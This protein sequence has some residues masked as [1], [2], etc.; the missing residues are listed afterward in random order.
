MSSVSEPLAP[1]STSVDS[2]VADP[3]TSTAEASSDASPATD[4]TPAD[5]APTDKP[6]DPALVTAGIATLTADDAPAL[7]RPKRKR[8]WLR[9]VG[10]VAGVA[11]I[12]TMTA[13]TGYVSDHHHVHIGVYP[14]PAS[15][16]TSPAVLRTSPEAKSHAGNLARFL[17][18]VPSGGKQNFKPR[19]TH[20]VMSLKQVTSYF[21]NPAGA[22][23]N[24]KAA[25]FVTAATENWYDKANNA[26]EIRMFRFDSDTDAFNWYGE[27]TGSYWADT[28][29][30]GAVGTTNH[31]VPENH[32]MTFTNGKKDKYHQQLTE[33]IA[34][35][36]DVVILMWVYQDA[37]QSAYY[38]DMLCYQQWSRL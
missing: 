25:G 12:V 4:S 38:V 30:K 10:W 19:A 26:V 36:G 24:L 5:S 6:T 31:R 15:T 8:R 34:V 32:G 13:A 11:V 7:P 33:A 21:D 3:T 27:Q 20:G 29:M 2:T 14:E 22:A 16:Y 35:H 23:S 28:A 17:M 18:P 9:G 37:P 1:T